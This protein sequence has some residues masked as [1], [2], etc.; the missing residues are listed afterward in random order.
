[1]GELLSWAGMSWGRSF[2]TRTETPGGRKYPIGR[3]LP[4]SS[5]MGEAVSC[6]T[7]GPKL[8]GGPYRFYTGVVGVSD[9]P[10]NNDSRS[11]T[12][13]NEWLPRSLTPSHEWLPPGKNDSPPT[14]FVYQSER[15]QRRATISKST[16]IPQKT[17]IQDWICCPY[18]MYTVAYCGLF[19]YW[20]AHYSYSEAGRTCTVYMTVKQ[21]GDCHWLHVSQIRKTI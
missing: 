10:L 11:L 20:S 2:C 1:M 8:M 14:Y 13:R 19:Y 7:G 17:T 15:L 18:I 3:K 12:P 21:Q 16:W 5:Y 6:D 4:R 9:S